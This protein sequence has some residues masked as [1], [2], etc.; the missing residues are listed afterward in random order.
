M[1]TIGVAHAAPSGDFIA[2]AIAAETVA[3]RIE[4]A[5]AN[6]RAQDGLKGKLGIV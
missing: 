2:R 4:L 5:D 3:A 1:G 6:A